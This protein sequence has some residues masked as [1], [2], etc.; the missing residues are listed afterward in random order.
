M[1]AI[2]KIEQ[3]SY[4]VSLIQMKSKETSGTQIFSNIFRFE[5]I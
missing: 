1:M 4:I 5:I 2:A 3:A